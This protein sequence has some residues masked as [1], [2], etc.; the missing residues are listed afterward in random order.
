MSTYNHPL[1]Y[2][3]MPLFFL[4]EDKKSVGETTLEAF[5]REW[6][7]G[8]P[9]RAWFVEENT[10]A[11]IEEARDE[12][13]EFTYPDGSVEPAVPAKDAVIGT[14][15][16]V[17]ERGNYFSGSKLIETFD[18]EDEAN[19]YHLNGLYWNYCESNRATD[20]PYSSSNREDIEQEIK[21]LAEMEAEEE[22]GE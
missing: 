12:E 17:R 20:A 1:S 18:T 13:K 11:V 19:Q 7:E 22:A 16:E 21:T 14:K 5:L 15:W 9:A 8:D 3:Q 10:K 2:F 4:G 6:Y